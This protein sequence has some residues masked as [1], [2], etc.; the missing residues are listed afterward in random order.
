MNVHV[1][2]Y[3]LNNLAQVQYLKTAT[4][5]ETEHSLSCV[6]VLDC[7][8]LFIALPTGAQRNSP[9]IS[10]ITNNSERQPRLSIITHETQRVK[11]K[12]EMKS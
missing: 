12:I 8:F 3:N 10:V 5:N 11:H 2:L 4:V 7:S 6:S 9:S 1:V